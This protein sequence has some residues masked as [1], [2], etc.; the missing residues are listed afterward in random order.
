MKTELVTYTKDLVVG[1]GKCKWVYLTAPFLHLP[2][3]SDLQLFSDDNWELV[4]IIE[5]KGINPNLGNP[6]PGVI[7]QQFN[8]GFNYKAYFKKYVEVIEEERSI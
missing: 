1:N 3:Q 7:A 4:T 5:D 6:Y 2:T 8:S